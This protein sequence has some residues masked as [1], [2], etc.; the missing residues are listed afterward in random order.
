MTLLLFA[1]SCTPDGEPKDRSQDTTTSMPADTADTRDFM[2]E[3]PSFQSARNCSECHPRQYSEWRGSMHAY[4]ALSPVFDAMAAKAF[5]DTAGEVGTFCTGCHTPQGTAEG[6]PGSTVA[7]QRS[8]LSREG[9]TCDV[10]HSAV[11]HTVPIGNTSLVF[12]TGDVKVGPFVSDAT[13]GHSSVQSDFLTSP[14]LCGSCHDVFNFPALN[15]EEAF[16]EYL[17]SPASSSGERCQDCHMGPDPGR[18]STREQAPA[19]IVPDGV[20]Y[21]E[22]AI[23]SHRF[24]GPDYSLID[25]F[26][27]PDD[28]AASAIAQEEYAGQVLTLLRNAVEISDAQTQLSGGVLQVQVDV[29][30]LTTGHNVP[31]G[32]TSERQLWIEVTVTGQS[33]TVHFRSG[34]LD[35]Y[36]DLRDDHSWEVIAGDVERDDSLH[37]F[38]S[39]NLFRRAASFEIVETIFPF[40]ATFIYRRSLTPL[41]VRS[42]NYTMPSPGEPVQ[43][44]VALKYRNLPP[45]VLRALGLD[46]ERLRIF[47]IDTR[48]LQVP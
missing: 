11:D 33:G 43:V 32:F 20:V 41:E 22:R 21:P 34:D 25:E 15:I 18:P 4:A 46:T 9:V 6:E 36:G 48:E 14:K 1:L 39:Q 28:L 27:Y 8:D 2:E 35:A 40:D 45:Y 23:S 5:R 10:C 7:E 17:L 13:E 44:S 3:P 29:H 16:T 42:L 24:I 30:S 12:S 38:Q 26:P 47:T 31:T 37:N 19:A